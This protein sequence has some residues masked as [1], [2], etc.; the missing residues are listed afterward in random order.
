MQIFDRDEF[1]YIGVRHG[2][3]FIA[4]LFDISISTNYSVLKLFCVLVLK[5]LCGKIVI[6]KKNS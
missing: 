5:I 1:E 6:Y 4:Q 3:S 2:A